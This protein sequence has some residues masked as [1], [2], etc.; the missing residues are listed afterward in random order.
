MHAR[1]RV[2]WKREKDTFDGTVVEVS[3]ELQHGGSQKYKYRVQYD[4]GDCVWHE[5]GHNLAMV[6]PA[7]GG[8]SDAAAAAQPQGP[9]ENSDIYSAVKKRCS[10]RVV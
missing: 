8:E 2:F 7:E 1:V 6:I 3:Q 4:D 5:T 9:S 10:A